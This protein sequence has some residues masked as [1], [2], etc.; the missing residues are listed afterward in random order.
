MNKR[1]A[2]RRTQRP[3]GDSRTRTG[4]TGG[5]HRRQMNEQHMG[6]GRDGY[7]DEALTLVSLFGRSDSNLQTYVSMQIR[8]ATRKSCWIR[9]RPLMNARN[10]M[11][12]LYGA[13]IKLYAL[14][15]DLLQTGNPFVDEDR[16]MIVTCGRFFVCHRLMKLM[17]QYIYRDQEDETTTGRPQRRIHS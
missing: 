4:Y 3:D 14:Q 13:C 12:S 11:K 15:D 16:E 8:T 7:E 9:S 1:M 2:G 10:S 17:W 6:T 5:M